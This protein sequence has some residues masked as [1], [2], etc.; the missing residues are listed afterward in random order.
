MFQ[1]E[2]SKF[3]VAGDKPPRRNI[4]KKVWGN[5]VQVVE[6]LG[7]VSAGHRNTGR[8]IPGSRLFRAAERLVW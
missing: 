7:V 5:R 3:S 8:N 6:R 1:V 4:L 2:H